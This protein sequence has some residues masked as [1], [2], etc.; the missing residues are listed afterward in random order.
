MTTNNNYG[1]IFEECYQELS[2]SDRKRCDK[3]LKFIAERVRYYKPRN[4][5]Q[6]G[7][8]AAAE[9]LTALMVK[10]YL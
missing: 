2:P 4:K 5:A 8:K 1:Q 6:F 9:L 7:P 10:G 3:E